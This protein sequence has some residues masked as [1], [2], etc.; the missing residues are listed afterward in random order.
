M[1]QR[2]NQALLATQQR[3]SQ[4]IHAALTA[5]RVPPPCREWR[6]RVAPADA[7]V[8][9]ATTAPPCR[10]L[11][12]PLEYV[13][14]GPDSVVRCS[15][16]PSSR[17]AAPLL[18]ASLPRNVCP[19]LRHLAYSSSTRQHWCA[20]QGAELRRRRAVSSPARYSPSAPPDLPACPTLTLENWSV[21]SAPRWSCP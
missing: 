17:A 8:S 5:G 12:R 19:A 13:L 11:W 21:D 14:C 9:T 10:L 2:L 16:A 18:L 6:L 20:H 4:G 7:K 15:T 1:I 3:R